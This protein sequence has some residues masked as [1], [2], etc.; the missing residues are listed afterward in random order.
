MV[1]CW[2]SQVLRGHLIKLL[3]PIMPS[4]LGNCIFYFYAGLRHNANCIKSGYTKKT[5]VLSRG[6]D[7]ELLLLDSNLSS[8]W[9]R[10]VN[11]KKKRFE[12]SNDRNKPIVLKQLIRFQFC[13]ENP[14]T[15]FHTFKK[16]TILRITP[17]RRSS[18]NRPSVY[19]QS[20]H[21]TG[22]HAIMSVLLLADITYTA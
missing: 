7:S 8:V 12:T 20:V 11:G 16:V 10:M 3:S 18:L 13:K 5:N 14:T 1:L 6:A 22:S 2:H 17:I 9:K 4:T 21:I 19:T 15:F